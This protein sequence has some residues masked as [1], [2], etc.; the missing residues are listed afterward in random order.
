MVHGFAAFA[1]GFNGDL[2]VLFEPRLAGEIAQPPRTQT[3]FELE[4]VFRR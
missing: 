1:R 4:I 3:G 2:Q